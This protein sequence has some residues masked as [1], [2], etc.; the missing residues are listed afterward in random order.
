LALVS[1]GFLAIFPPASCCKSKTKSSI[2]LIARLIVE[3][4]LVFTVFRNTEN[5]RIRYITAT[6]KG[7]VA[8]ENTFGQ[9]QNWEINLSRDLLGNSIN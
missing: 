3:C 2:A 1:G 4:N 7:F 9:Q 8:I 5:S 6:D